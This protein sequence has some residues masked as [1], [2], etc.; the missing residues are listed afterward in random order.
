LI[1]Y[2]RGR[3]FSRIRTVYMEHTRRRAIVATHVAGASA[4]CVAPN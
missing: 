2:A 1:L 4:R 3:G